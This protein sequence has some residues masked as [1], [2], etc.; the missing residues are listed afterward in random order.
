[1][2]SGITAKSASAFGAEWVSGRRRAFF[3]SFIFGFVVRLIPEVLSFPYPIGYDPIYLYAWRIRGG[4]VWYHWSQ[5]FSTWL[6]YAFLIP[7]YNVVQGDPFVLLKFGAALLFGFNACGIYYFATKALGWTV[8]KGLLAS[9]FFSLQM[10]ALAFSLNFYRNMLGLGIL[11]FALPLVKDD[12]RSTRRFLVFVLLSVLMVFG[13]EYSSVILFTVVLGFLV[14]RFLKGT[15]INVLKVLMAVFPALALFLVSFY[16]IV[17]PIPY[18]VEKNVISV[19]EPTGNYHGALFFLRNYLAVYEPVEYYP[20]YLDIVSQVVSLFA[21]LYIVALPLVLVGLFKDNV[22]DSWTALLLIGSFGALVTPFFALDWW[23][24]WMLMLVYPFSFYAVNGITKILRSIHKTQV[25][26]KKLSEIAVKLILILPFFP[27]LVLMS[28]MANGMYGSSVPLRDVDDTISAIQWLDAQ[29][30]DGSALLAHKG[31]F[32]WARL[33]LDKRRILVYF[34]DDI[35]GAIDV[36][37]QQGLN[38]V[39][40]VWWNENIGWYGLT[41]PNGFI[42]VFTSDRISVFKYLSHGA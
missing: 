41:V 30:D 42:A 11:L 27:G 21:G 7:L 19:Y 34:R 3:L 31:F 36:A 4:V 24:R 9:V 39:Y 18:G 33:Y 14:R 35:E 6:L 40:F 38:D 20:M 23:Y 29:M 10:A 12:F 1:M 22:L 2:F 8:K 26:W 25:R 37:L 17:F 28:S 15:K 16:L 32:S 5:V 13:H